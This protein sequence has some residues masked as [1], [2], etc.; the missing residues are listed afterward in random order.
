MS[1][2]FMS[3]L[4][5]VVAS[6]SLALFALAGSASADVG[7]LIQPSSSL[8]GYAEVTIAQVSVP[9]EDDYVPEIVITAIPQTD[10]GT[11]GDPALGAAA[12]NSL[13]G[14]GGGYFFTK[15]TVNH[16]N[17]FLEEI[18][19]GPDPVGPSFDPLTVDAV[20]TGNWL[21]NQAEPDGGTGTNEPMNFGTAVPANNAATLWTQSPLTGFNFYT[22][23][24]FSAASRDNGRISVWGLQALPTDF[25]DGPID[26]NPLTGAFSAENTHFAGVTG[27]S[28]NLNIAI[29]PG[30]EFDA[31]TIPPEFFLGLGEDGNSPPITDN[32]LTGAAAMGSISRGPASASGAAWVLT[33]PYLTEI[34]VSPE[35]SVFIQFDMVAHANLVPG[36]TNFDGVVNI[37]DLTNMATA[38]LSPGTN[39][40]G[41]DATGDGVVNI[42]DLTLAATNY[43]DTSPPLPGGGGGGI[44]SVP[45]PSSLLLLGIGA[46]SMLFVARRRVR[47]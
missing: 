12:K 36:D 2:S 25:N 17:N 24:D 38:Y 44:A 47:R 26:V 4:T 41:V 21:P 14:S 32:A 9:G 15:S 28:L 20:N 34:E 39:L 16:G 45:E 1:S 29:I 23:L 35:L 33:Q 3:K 42:S 6:L 8:G 27:I 43:L 13:E 40:R 19:Y 22:G 46:V 37:T 5:P 30:A 18:S 31:I 11:D 10:V 7:W